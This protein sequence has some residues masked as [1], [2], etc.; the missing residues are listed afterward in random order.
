MLTLS[1]KD[2]TVNSVGSWQTNGV[3]YE[4]FQGGSN[5][6]NFF[7]AAPDADLRAGNEEGPRWYDRVAHFVGRYWKG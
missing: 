2:D 5:K 1:D 3:T 6:L 4:L 7:L